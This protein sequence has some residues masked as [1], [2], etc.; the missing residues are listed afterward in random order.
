M[1]KK[2]A[3]QL[4]CVMKKVNPSSEAEISLYLIPMS[5]DIN[6][7][8]MQGTTKHFLCSLLACLN[9]CDMSLRQEK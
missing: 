2:G 7:T 9:L 1:L 4:Q 8:A 6:L 3:L 5:S